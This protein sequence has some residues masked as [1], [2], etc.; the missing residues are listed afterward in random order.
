MTRPTHSTFAL[1]ASLALFA[2]S[3]TDGTATTPGTAD[4]GGTGGSGAGGGGTGGG[5]TKDGGGTGSHLEHVIVIAFENHDE[6]SVIGNTTD[7]PYING[8]LLPR[9]ASASN[10]QD[11]LPILTPSEPHYVLMEAGTATFSDATFTNDAVPS[12]ANSTASTDHLVNQLEA[13]NHTWMSYQEGMNAATGPCPIVSDGFYQPKHDP[14][15][16]FQDVAGNPPDQNAARCVA[17]HAPIEAFFDAIAGNGDLPDYAFVTPNQCN[18]MHGQGGCPN[19]N[20]VNSGDAWLADELPG[21]ISYAESHH[22]AIFLVWDE[23]ELSPTIPFV[24]VGP[25]VKAGYVSD[26]KVTHGSLIRTVENVFGLPALSTVATENDFSDF[27]EGG[28]LP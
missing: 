10:F 21:V 11:T 9:Y 16:F 25:D 19:T 23:G 5:G 14:F 8:E 12:A 28:A 13:A 27:F 2:C 7:A 6:T 20:L 3:S 24:A 18:D 17:H 26:V 15:L 22:A 1:L 4:G